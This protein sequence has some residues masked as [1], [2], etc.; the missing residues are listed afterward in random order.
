MRDGWEDS[1]GG[2]QEGRVR[3]QERKRGEKK[4]KGEKEHRAEGRNDLTLLGKTPLRANF[5][6]FAHKVKVVLG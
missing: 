4:K 1:G 2:L 5:S 3:D 6:L